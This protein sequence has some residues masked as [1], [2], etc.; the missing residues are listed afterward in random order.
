MDFV[1][2]GRQTDPRI[3]TARDATRRNEVDQA[4]KVNQK[5]S[6][7]KMD[8]PRKRKR[9]STNAQE[10]LKT[11]GEVNIQKEVPGARSGVTGKTLD[12]NRD[13]ALGEKKKLLHKKCKETN[14]AAST[15]TE[16]GTA[17]TAK[18]TN[19]NQRFIPSPSP[20]DLSTAKLLSNSS[21]VDMVP[22][23]LPTSPPQQASEHSNWETKGTSH[24]CNPSAYI[25]ENSLIGSNKSGSGVPATSVLDLEEAMNK[26]LPVGQSSGS[27]N[28][29][30]LGTYSHHNNHHQSSLL[31][32]VQKQQAVQ[33]MGPG[34]YSVD[35]Q[36][37]GTHS[38]DLSAASLLRSL[39][40]S[41]ES[42]IRTNVY[43]SRCIGM[44]STSSA[45][46]SAAAAQYYSNIQCAL[47]T[48]P[49]GGNDNNDLY[50][51]SFAASILNHSKSASNGYSLMNGY[52]PSV[53]GGGCL[54]TSSLNMADAYTIT[55]PSSVSPLEGGH[56]FLASSSSTGERDVAA[57]AA[58]MQGYC[59]LPIRPHAYSLS[60]GYDQQSALGPYSGYYSASNLASTYHCMAGAGAVVAAS[61]AAQYRD[62]M[63]HA[64]SW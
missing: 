19:E 50:C 40:P 47:L 6:R 64:N 7:R 46:Y 3:L 60:G 39:Y 54:G 56:P 24:D 49:S 14:S 43:G 45:S 59:G 15:S 48:P 34:A 31:G 18:D 36:S 38:S 35:G 8:K 16:L 5:N 44:P 27:V 42:V 37:V 41:R 53:V 61:A 13:I 28:D 51:N 4:S 62:A 1:D 57:T 22:Q 11:K 20:E 32:S 30:L 2:I 25:S 63:K 21:T 29:E 12:A 52:T 33:W 9:A 23:A 17:E 10:S 55:P 58:M 26:H